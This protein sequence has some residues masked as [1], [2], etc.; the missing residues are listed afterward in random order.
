VKNSTI[1]SNK[2]LLNK[3]CFLAFG[4]RPLRLFSPILMFFAAGGG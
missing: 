3:E 2:I 1:T 4:G